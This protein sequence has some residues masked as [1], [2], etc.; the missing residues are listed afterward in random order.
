MKL[1]ELEIEQLE[2]DNR[3]EVAA[4]ALEE[5]ELMTKASA[6]GL[7][8]LSELFT[9]KISVKNKKFVQ[10]LVNSS[11]A[12]NMAD[13]ANEPSFHFY[14]SIAQSNQAIVQRPSTQHPNSLS[15]LCTHGQVEAS[16]NL[17][18]HKPQEPSRKNNVTNDAHNAN[19]IMQEQQ[20]P[21]YT[22]PSPP[23]NFGMS[24]QLNAPNT[25]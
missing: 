11:P 4:A 23:I 21:Q 3:K 15:N 18:V 8:T 2:D 16:I 10:D 6:E 5:I 25:A 14:G 24:T 20:Q 12:G 17:P 7:G 1:R 13:D 22:L 9:E 19:N